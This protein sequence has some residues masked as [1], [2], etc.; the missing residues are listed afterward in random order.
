M[1]AIGLAAVWLVVLVTYGYALAVSPTTLGGVVAAVA[2]AGIVVTGLLYA[3]R[4]VTG[5]SIE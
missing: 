4:A 5:A 1:A 3:W 2:L